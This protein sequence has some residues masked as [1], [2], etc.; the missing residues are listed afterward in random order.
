MTTKEIENIAYNHLWKKGA[1]LCFEVA[2]PKELVSRYHRERVDLLMYETTGVWKCFEIKNSVSD[3]RSS[4]KLSFW[5]D[6]NYYI[7]NA[8]IYP[9][10]KDEIPDGIGVW[11]AYKPHE[12]MRGYMECVK[13]PKRRERLC[14][15]EALMFAL[16][17]GLSR[18]YKKYRKIKEKE[19]K[20][21]KKS[22]KKKISKKNVDKLE[23]LFEDNDFLL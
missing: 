9:K 8:D 20:V 11:L 19:E 13:K 1:Y 17:Q 15:H 14:S 22:S 21:S 10:V 2:A 3:F 18:E 6:Y 7:L 12:D 5:G 16:M 23:S 4:A